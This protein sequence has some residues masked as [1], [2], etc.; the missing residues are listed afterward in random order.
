MSKIEDVARAIID[1][2]DPV[3]R[4]LDEW[5]RDCAR[6]AIKAMRVPTDAMIVAGQEK[7]FLSERDPG[8]VEADW[9]AMIT[10]ALEEKP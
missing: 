9:E 7:Y 5:A 10:A 2:G 8:D 4:D 3:S 1:V 6:A